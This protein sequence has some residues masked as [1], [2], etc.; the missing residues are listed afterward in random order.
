MR[1]KK[2]KRHRRA[3]RFFIACFGF[4]QPFK[5]LCDGTFVHH[6]IVNNI[7]PAD[8]ALSSILGGPVKL[9]T[10]RC[11]IAELKRLGSSYSES[12]Q[13][14]QRL[15]VA[16]C[17]HEAIKSGESCIG[18]IIGENNPEHFFLATQDADLRKKFQSVPGVP[19]IFALRN[20][21]FLE[22]PSAF[23][24]QVAKN[25]EEER[26]HMTGLE[27]KML[28][29]RTDSLL[30]NQEPRDSFDEDEGQRDHNKE[31]QPVKKTHIGRNR[32]VA[33]DRPQLKR[34]KAKAPNPLS[35]KKKKKHENSIRV[36]VKEGRDAE[37]TARS[38]SR[39]RKR[40][41]KGK[42]LGEGDIH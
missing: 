17:D 30:V 33:K 12:L 22:P 16:R 39:K 8:N 38:G 31:M 37:N 35:Q 34:K 3:V 23:Q 36:P 18:D 27:Y 6:L 15:M 14:A 2:Q 26:L 19:L 41:R 7:T 32:T 24:R 10:T 5:I 28:K 4:R 13:A 9:F 42:K 25:S 1:L 21:L 29:K 20:A 40:S 11:V